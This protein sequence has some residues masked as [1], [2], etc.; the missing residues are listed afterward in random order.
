[1]RAHVCVP[2]LLSS[3]GLHSRHAAAATPTHAHGA[4]E[5]CSCTTLNVTLSK[6]LHIT[7]ST[8]APT[9]IVTASRV[10]LYRYYVIPAGLGMRPWYVVYRRCGETRRT[11]SYL[12]SVVQSQTPFNPSS[13]TGWGRQL[14]GVATTPISSSPSGSCSR[15]PT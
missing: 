7:T 14:S 15:Q 10:V 3:H 2:V 8:V 6:S 9:V 12:L 11:C 4:H 1:M 13:T 5:N